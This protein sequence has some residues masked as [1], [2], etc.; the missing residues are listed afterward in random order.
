MDHTPPAAP[1][2]PPVHY[3]TAG[4]RVASGRFLP[5][6]HST[7]F[8]RSFLGLTP[9][10]FSVRTIGF[11]S[12]PHK[13]PF[14]AKCGDLM[15]RGSKD[16]Y[17]GAMQGVAGTG[18]RW[19]KVGG[20]AAEEVYGTFFGYKVCR[21]PQRFALRLPKTKPILRENHPK[22]TRCIRRF[23][24]ASFSGPPKTRLNYGFSAVLGRPYSDP[25]EMKA[26]SRN[27]AMSPRF[28]IRST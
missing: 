8:P 27:F 3:A 22:H 23:S 6:A 10:Q 24:A 26:E 28:E 17:W 14:L 19:G 7:S 13:P 5:F 2:H 9:P 25:L 1:P 4:R 11:R 18:G 20:C 12:F 16:R 21:E 15:S